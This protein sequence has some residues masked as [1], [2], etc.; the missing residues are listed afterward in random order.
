MSYKRLRT[1][2]YSLSRLTGLEHLDIG[3]NGLLYLP[4]WMGNLRELKR[5]EMAR[6]ALVEVPKCLECLAKLTYLD[7]SDMIGFPGTSPP[8]VG[9]LRLVSRPPRRFNMRLQ[10][11]GRAIYAVC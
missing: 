5:L 10:L 9:R 4:G 3:H 2:P 7:M 6:I 1:L 8:S 11:R